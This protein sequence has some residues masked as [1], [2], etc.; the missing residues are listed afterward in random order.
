ML[1]DVDGS[2]ARPGGRRTSALLCLLILSLN[3]RVSGDS[4]IEA[5]WGGGS[6]E[7]SESGLDTLV[8]R[9][10][11]V[12]EPHREPRQP[13]RV[14]VND[15]GGYRLLLNEDQVD[16]HRFEALADESRELLIAGEPD[17]AL[18]RS[19]EALKL[20]RGEPFGI[21]ADEGWAAAARGRLEKILLEVKER[22]LDALLAVGNPVR[23]AA[24]A[25][26]LAQEMPLR[27]GLW[28]R[29]MLSCYRAGQVDESL[30]HY[31][32]VRRLLREQLGTEP[33]RELQ[34]LQQRILAADPH[35]ELRSVP[36][37]ATT[38]S[39]SAATNPPES[40]PDPTSPAERHL[41]RWMTPLIGRDVEL[42][43]LADLVR[44][45][46]LATVVGTA[47]CGK[48]RLA[49]AVASTLAAHF[50]DG[51]WFV[52]LSAIDDPDMVLDVTMSAVGLGTAQP[53]S[54]VEQLRAHVRNRRLLLL[55]DNCEHVLPKVRELVGLLLEPDAEF[56]LLA[57][58]REPLD[59]DGELVWTLSPLPVHDADEAP[60]L[61]DDE[62]FGPD[63]GQVP[64]SPAAE[65]FL[66]RLK[67][68]IPDQVL[69]AGAIRTAE[70]ICAAADGV[71]LA[72][73]LGA[74]R[75]RSSTLSEIAEQ[76]AAD[77]A[78]ITR[79]GH[80]R[81]GARHTVAAAIERSYRLL[82][83]EEQTAHRRLAV[84]PGLFT[85]D[86]A[87]AVIDSSD[88]TRT[89]PPAADLLADLVHRSLLTFQ[90]PQR[91]ADP[92]RFTQLATVRAHA[93]RALRAS[94]EARSAEERRDQ[95]VL[96]LTE[97]RP[98]LAHA[99][100]DGWY[101]Q[102]N[103]SFDVIRASLQRHLIDQ[104]NPTGPQLIA[105]LA[106]FWV[107]QGRVAESTRWLVPALN[108]VDL[109]TADGVL[110]GITYT[111]L[112]MSLG[113]VDLARPAVDQCLTYQPEKGQ[114]DEDAVALLSLGALVAATY[115][116]ATL[117]MTLGAAVTRLSRENPEHRPISQFSES[118]KGLVDLLNQAPPDHERLIPLHE[119]AIRTGNLM[120]AW[121]AS[122]VLYL[123]AEVGNDAKS[124][125]IWTD[126][127]I[128]TIRALGVRYIGPWMEARA[129]LL[130]DMGRD[131][132]QSVVQQ[133]WARNQVRRGGLRW[134]QRPDTIDV[135]SQARSALGT[136]RFDK[137]WH[138]GST[139]DTDD[140][141]AVSESP[142]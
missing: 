83:E 18:R 20:W 10:R 7:Q 66:A 84:L 5:V 94:G 31:Q 107:Y 36:P 22:R 51:A 82:S 109:S 118:I 41:P 69:D 98:G 60:D 1:V 137:A 8:W 121:I 80:D 9:L 127:V 130:F 35:L 16:S 28:A 102:V 73:E 138:H 100:H 135:L 27:E 75:A 89:L 117:G 96:A 38:L 47:G 15:A 114:A 123:L 12:L 74:A 55:L 97:R 70:R 112:Q 116:E 45:T 44:L 30:Q 3:R 29:L 142:M 14:L 81:S 33:G 131:S 88:V 113:R 125:L 40:R 46:P 23:A 126:R 104:P 79:P 65:L 139:L 124:K 6:N 91:S 134:P 106:N 4:L 42:G 76:M 56:A 34:E 132:T 115:G 50:P 103:Q 105:R 24:D 13:P 2:A 136:T 39:T 21:H 128:D 67:Q 87:A 63:E 120:A 71:P 77:P 101:G 49:V 93:S 78:G 48:T 53:G 68:I 52:D 92:S 140:P 90:P 85:A 17:R 43:Q 86:A 72:I 61:I 19:E 133:A 129:N 37:T 58:S 26:I 108:L 57:T 62:G 59:I 95:W 99:D 122:A 111:I 64:I 119:E 54:A 141:R 25:G 110:V 11:R 32:R